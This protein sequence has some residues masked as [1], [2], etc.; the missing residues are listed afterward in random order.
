MDSLQQQLI[1]SQVVVCNRRNAALVDE[2]L[3]DIT[4]AGGLTDDDKTMI[5]DMTYGEG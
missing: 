3:K 5:L 1:D 2:V 4:K